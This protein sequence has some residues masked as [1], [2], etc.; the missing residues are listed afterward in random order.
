[1]YLLF[2]ALFYL[3]KNHNPPPTTHMQPSERLQVLEFQIY[4]SS[5]HYLFE[6]G[7]T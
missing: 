3:K 7:I 2:T 5:A 4:I 6:T 1:M